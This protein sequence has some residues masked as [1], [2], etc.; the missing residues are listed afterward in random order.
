MAPRQCHIHR[1]ET[2]NSLMN[3]WPHI[4]YLI[5]I[6]YTL[7]CLRLLFIAFFL[8]WYCRRLSQQCASKVLW[9]FLGDAKISH[10]EWQSLCYLAISSV[11]LSR[12]R[13][14]I[15]HS[16]VCSTM[17]V[18]TLKGVNS[19]IS[20]KITFFIS[21]AISTAMLAYFLNFSSKVLPQSIYHGTHISRWIDF[22]T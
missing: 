21:T 10:R 15:K 19:D 13:I 22:T 4:V 14:F 1:V 20:I 17:C 8:V 2:A 9:L 7:C 3:R 18:H 6:Y 16:H 5:L 11:V 12:H